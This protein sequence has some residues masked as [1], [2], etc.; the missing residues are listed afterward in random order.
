MV[1]GVAAIDAVVAV[2]IYQLTEIFVGLNQS[3]GILCRVAEVYV[4]VGHT[5]TKQQGS[6]QLTATGYRTVVVT[7][8]I[9]MWGSHVALRIDG[10]IV[11]P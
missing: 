5:V 2:R 4:V 8:G 1:T 11:A 7:R 6:V 9:F 10:I 3:L